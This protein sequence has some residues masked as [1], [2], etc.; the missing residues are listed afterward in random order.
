VQLALQYLQELYPD[1]NI[2]EEYAGSACEE[3]FL[4]EAS[5]IDWAA[6][7]PLGDAT[8]YAN[9]FTTLWPRMVLPR[10][11][12]F[13]AGEHLSVYHTWIVGAMDSAKVAVQQLLRKNIDPKATVSFLKP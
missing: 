11:N 8:F 2:P 4:K 13:F 10:G 3:D 1:V 5:P 9:Q 12:I 7:W 6:K